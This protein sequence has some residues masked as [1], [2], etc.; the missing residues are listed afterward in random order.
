VHPSLAQTMI[1]ARVAELHRTAQHSRSRRRADPEGTPEVRR[2]RRAT[3]WFLV[4]LGLRLAVP[5]QA[6]PVAYR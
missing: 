5:G 2:V 1:D 3:G 4:D 6:R